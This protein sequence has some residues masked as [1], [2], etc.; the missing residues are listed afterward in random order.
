MSDDIQS[1]VGEEACLKCIDYTRSVIEAIN[2]KLNEINDELPDTKEGAIMQKT[3]IGSVTTHLLAYIFE[4][5]GK[6]IFEASERYIQLLRKTAL[7][8][9]L[10]RVVGDDKDE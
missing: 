6:D 10:H 1:T 3:I 5:F 4:D 2:N 8:N 9:L 7:I